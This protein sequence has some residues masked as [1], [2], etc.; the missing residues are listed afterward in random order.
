VALGLVLGVALGVALGLALGLALGVA[1]GVDSPQPLISIPDTKT[2]STK[3][4]KIFF[5]TIPL[6]IQKILGCE[7][8]G[9]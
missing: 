1:L 8:H 5:I 7:V 4:K 3:T 2:S 9:E 6:L